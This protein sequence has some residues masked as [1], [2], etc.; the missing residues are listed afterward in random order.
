MSSI[1]LSKSGPINIDNNDSSIS[2]CS[3]KSCILQFNYNLSNIN[4]KK[5]KKQ[6]YIYFDKNNY[7]TYNNIVYKLDYATFTDSSSHLLNNTPYD[8][9]LYI[10]H[11]RYT[12]SKKK[13]ILNVLI[14]KS[15][16]IYTTNKFFKKFKNKQYPKNNGDEVL[17]CDYKCKLNPYLMLPDSKQFYEYGNKRIKNIVFKK[18]INISS[19]IIDNIKKHITLTPDELN[20]KFD[21]T[22]NFSNTKIINNNN[23]G[24][25]IVS[26][27]KLRNQCVNIYKSNP[28]E[29]NKYKDNRYLILYFKILC[30]GV[31]IFL[32]GYV[33]NKIYQIEK[34]KSLINTI[35]NKIKN[36]EIS[37]QHITLIFILIIG[38]VIFSLFT[39]DDISSNEKIDFK[40]NLSLSNEE[41]AVDDLNKESDDLNDMEEEAYVQAEELIN[42]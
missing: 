40:Y 6:L 16:D 34:I 24:I 33:L 22:I 13:L 23:D 17:I 21:E 15:D 39:M 20:T 2:T 11:S 3:K 36:T 14:N 7:I 32:L 30:I 31:S 27:K 29:F 12:N 1:N 19:K 35:I 5:K 25:S 10:V 8:L 42:N 4:L 28:K 38:L 37:T 18:Y 41:E 9:E 26:D